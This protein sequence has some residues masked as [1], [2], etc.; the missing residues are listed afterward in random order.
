MN[1][2]LLIDAII[3][4]TTVLIAQLSTAAGIRSPLAQVADEVFVSLAREIEQQGLSRKVVADMFGMAL[5][6]YQRKVQR[7]EESRSRRG[8]TLWEAIFEHVSANTPI[9]RADIAIH[10]A[11]DDELAVSSVLM[12][13]VTSGLL[14]TVGRGDT[15]VY[16][17]S[18]DADRRALETEDSIET[19]ALL[20]WGIVFR[21][22]GMSTEELLKVAGASEPEVR[23]SLDR[24][25]ATGRITRE[26]EG[27]EA[28]LNSSSFVIA[29]NAAQGWEA[30]VFDH[31]QA[32]ARAIAQKAKGRTSPSPATEHS[33]GAT[34]HFGVF[35]GHPYEQR[36]LGLLR[37][38]RD[39]VNT[40][41]K[42]VASY[43]EQNQITE[44]MTTRVTFYFGQHVVALEE[45]NAGAAVR[46]Q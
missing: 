44:D 20:L 32:V 15:A 17:M 5:R 4:Q 45:R 43:N 31:Y 1:S 22:P 24:L 21:S 27:D 30:A 46:E 38:F 11:Q 3:R 28:K 29:E 37:R 35:P 13:L 34:I 10:F 41:W 7:L 8:Q 23:G 2:R 9:R 33:G 36:V 25:I 19:L 39:D 12:D 42:E 40:F 6:T 14:Y 26:G 16:G 18:T